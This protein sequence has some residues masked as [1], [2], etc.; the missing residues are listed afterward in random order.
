MKKIF[1]IIILL[2][3]I[4]FSANSETKVVPITIG[5]ENAKV[6]I[7]VFESLTCS[8]CASFHKKILPNLKKDFIQTNKIKITFKSFPL[9]LAA[10]NASK[11]AHCKNDGD[12]KILHLLFQ[13]QEKWIVGKKLEDINSNL[14]EIIKKNNLDLNFEKCINDQNLENHIL[15]DRVIGVKKYKVNSTPTLFINQKKFEKTLTYKNLKKE[16]EKLL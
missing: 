8:H 3:I 2:F 5:N 13:N 15:D 6:Q 1:P 11:I 16:I 4:S 14:S 10:L 12:L 7:I 9:D